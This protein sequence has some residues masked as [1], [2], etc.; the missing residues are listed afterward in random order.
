MSMST[1]T[2]PFV[3]DPS[4]PRNKVIYQCTQTGEQLHD[5]EFKGELDIWTYFN[6]SNVVQVMSK[7][8]EIH[9]HPD[10]LA[11]FELERENEI[12]ALVVTFIHE[13][14]GDLEEQVNVEYWPADIWF[15]AKKRFEQ[16]VATGS[17]TSFAETAAA[18]YEKYILPISFTVQRK[19]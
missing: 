11:A 17:D 19:S 14:N 13:R 9:I 3:K 1:A 2:A 8:F 5:F 18:T 6:V 15:A 10:T 4:V 12:I 7:T 16:L